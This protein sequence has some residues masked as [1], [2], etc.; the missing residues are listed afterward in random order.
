MEVAFR[1]G[2]R[3]EKNVRRQ[4]EIGVETVE[5]R[6]GRR[7]DEERREFEAASGG[8]VEQRRGRRRVA[9]DRVGEKNAGGG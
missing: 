9:V 7:F 3:I 1:R 6:V 2:G 5:A 8:E 4:I